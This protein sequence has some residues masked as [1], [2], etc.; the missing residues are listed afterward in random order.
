MKS[1][2]LLLTSE[3]LL[4]QKQLFPLSLKYLELSLLLVVVL[5]LLAW[6]LLIGIAEVIVGNVEQLRS[7]RLVV[8][9]VD[10]KLLDPLL[11]G[12]ELLLKLLVLLLTVNFVTS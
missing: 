3:L 10:G 8:I 2:K 4:F 9:V 11:E 7:N 12:L 5:K 1:E 6:L